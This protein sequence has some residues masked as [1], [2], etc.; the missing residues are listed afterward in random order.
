VKIGS[1]LCSVDDFFHDLV[2][3]GSVDVGEVQFTV[4]SRK[5][6]GLDVFSERFHDSAA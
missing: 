3:G 2:V 5:R 1:A 6:S 4:H